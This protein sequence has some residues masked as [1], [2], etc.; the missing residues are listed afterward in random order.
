MPDENMTIWNAVCETDPAITKRV[1]YGKREFTN[2]CAQAQRK[3]A[4]ELW[5]PFGGRWGVRE[6]MF[7]YIR[8]AA[9]EIIELAYSADFY[10]PHDAEKTAGSRGFPI[11]SDEKYAP[12]QDCR[13]KV[14][15]DALTKGLSFLGFNSDIFEGK[16]DDNKYVAEMKAKYGNNERAGRDGTPEADMDHNGEQYPPERDNDNETF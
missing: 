8:N 1:K 11:S 7:E 13:K 14:A 10:F 4:T 6:A 3:R 16:F 15:T 9:G 5:G 12:G 2:A